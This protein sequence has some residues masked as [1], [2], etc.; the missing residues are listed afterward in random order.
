MMYQILNRLFGW[1]YVYWCNRADWGVARVRRDYSGGVFY[2]SYKFIKC[3]DRVAKPE[4]VVWLTCLPSKYFP[5][6]KEKDDD[7]AR[8]R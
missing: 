8:C 2:W 3:M 1:D 5:D 7:P 6:W 4:D